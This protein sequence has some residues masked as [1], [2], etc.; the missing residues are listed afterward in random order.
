MLA[1]RLRDVI[2][3]VARNRNAFGAECLEP[4]DLAPSQLVGRELAASGV[5]AIRYPAVAGKGTHVVVFLENVPHGGV[6]L[7]NRGELIHQISTIKNF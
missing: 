6:L 5:Q 4:D 7:F 3:G 2:H 1:G